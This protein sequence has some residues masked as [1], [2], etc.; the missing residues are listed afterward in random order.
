[1][2][3]FCGG[4]LRGF[5]GQNGPWAVRRDAEE[6]AEAPRA[7]QT[8]DWGGLHS[9]ELSSRALVF[10]S[11]SLSWERH[12]G[13]IDIQQGIIMSKF[14]WVYGRPRCTGDMG[15]MYS[16]GLGGL[17]GGQGVMLSR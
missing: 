14:L 15:W 6:P 7:I 16:A 8:G 9:E 1:M 4:C 13:Q 3:L 11:T 17:R 12:L 10:T 2:P 5:G